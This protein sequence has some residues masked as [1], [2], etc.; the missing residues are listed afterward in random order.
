MESI[1]NCIHT[2][3]WVTLRYGFDLKRVKVC[4]KRSVVNDQLCN[5]VIEPAVSFMK[6][7]YYHVGEPIFHIYES[8]V[9]M[10]FIN[11]VKVFYMHLCFVETF[12]LKECGKMQSKYAMKRN[13]LDLFY[14]YVLCYCLTIVI[15]F[16]SWM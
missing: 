6:L 3:E 15:F 13:L 9:P 4:W 1:Y 14:A 2:T 5:H 16:C 7:W 8:L 10:N 12:L 11:T